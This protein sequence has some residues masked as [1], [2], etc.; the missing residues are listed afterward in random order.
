MYAIK[1]CSLPAGRQLVIQSVVRA[2]APLP[3]RPQLLAQQAFD[4][5]APT[6]RTQQEAII[7]SC[8]CSRATIF[9]P[10][11]PAHTHAF[12][13]IYSIFCLFNYELCKYALA[14]C[15]M[16]GNLGAVFACAFSATMT[17]IELQQIRSQI[18]PR[19]SIK[20]EIKM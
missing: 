10:T 1:C 2:A 6:V 3:S 13:L 14:T 8:C 4:Q 5:V 18:A 17:V 20:H 9:L 7:F 19:K 15:G 11:A 12:A 16:F